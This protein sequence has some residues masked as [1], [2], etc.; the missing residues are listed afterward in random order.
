MVVHVLSSELSV[1]INNEEI[2]QHNTPTSTLLQHIADALYNGTN[3]TALDKIVLVDPSGVEK[4]YTTNLTFTVGDTLQVSGT[5]NVTESY[6]VAYIR[7]YGGGN[8]Y[9]ESAVSFSVNPGDQVQITI[10]ISLTLSGSL[11]GASFSDINLKS[12]IFKVLANQMSRTQLSIVY[13]VFNV[14]NLNTNETADYQQ[15]VSKSKPASNKVS[16]S[17]SYTPSYDWALNYVKVKASGGDLYRYTTS[18]TGY[19]NTT[20]TYSDTITVSA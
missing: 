10:T 5:I 18:I 9:F 12:F 1:K 15:S 3:L 19:A 2:R 6:S 7:T 4:D 20:I 13:V 8:K 11:S 17:G 14:T 16:F